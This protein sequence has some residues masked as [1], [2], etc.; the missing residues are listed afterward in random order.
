MAGIVYEF[1]NN[2]GIE[3]LV[4]V[5]YNPRTNGKFER[6]KHTIIISLRKHCEND[7]KAWDKWLPYVMMTYRSHL[8]SWYLVPL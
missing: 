1:C 7:N 3:K 5:A 8:M 4:T 2:V 6:L